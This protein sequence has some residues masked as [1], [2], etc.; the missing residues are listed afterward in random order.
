MGVVTLNADG[1][2]ECEPRGLLDGI[3]IIAP[4]P[5]LVLPEQGEDYLRTIPFQ[6]RRST[7]VYPVLHP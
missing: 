1:V 7:F 3:N 2:A 5:R 4:G 6:F